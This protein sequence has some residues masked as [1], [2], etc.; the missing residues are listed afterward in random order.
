MDHFQRRAVDADGWNVESM[1]AE[2]NDPKQR[3]SLIIMNSMKN[4]ILA[5]TRVAEA[6]AK[7]LDE[8]LNN[9]EQ[10]TRDGAALLNK[11]I[12]AWK[13]I[14]WILGLAQSALIACGTYLVSD[15]KELHADVQAQAV[16]TAEVKVRLTTIEGNVKKP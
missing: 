13:I 8:H 15:L 9:Y 4:A 10:Q 14:V 12:G 5:N 11:G 2:E 1:I 6:T 16:E 7:R 3:V